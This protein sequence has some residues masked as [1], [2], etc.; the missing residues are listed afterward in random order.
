[1]IKNFARVLAVEAAGEIDVDPAPD[2]SIGGSL[3][4]DPEIASELS[5]YAQELEI[6]KREAENSSVLGGTKEA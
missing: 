3:V 4:A 6:E 2:V 1:M 5:S